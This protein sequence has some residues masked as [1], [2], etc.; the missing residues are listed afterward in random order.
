MAR[1]AA[2]LVL[3][4]LGT[5]NL[6][7]AEYHTKKALIEVNDIRA[8]RNPVKSIRADAWKVVDV[9]GKIKPQQGQAV[10]VICEGDFPVGMIAN[11]LIRSN[12]EFNREFHVTALT[13]VRDICNQQ[14]DA[15]RVRNPRLFK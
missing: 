11:D 9:K 7:A 4:F 6:Q 8:D 5:Q 3:L 2:A 15:M 12:G 1:G 14:E 13:T 10:A